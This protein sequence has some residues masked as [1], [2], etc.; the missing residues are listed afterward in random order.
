MM[1]GVC[2]NHHI[3][4]VLRLLTLYLLNQPKPKEE[5]TAFVKG[6]IVLAIFFLMNILAGM[7]HAEVSSDIQDAYPYYAV[8]DSSV[9]G[10][11]NEMQLL[12]SGIASFQKRIDL[13]RKAKKRISIEYFIWEKDKAGL[14]LF[15]ELIKKAKEGVDVRIILDKSIT[16]IEMDEFFAEAVS[17]YGIDL[18]HYNRAVDPS[19]AQF[20]T[21]RKI[22]V[23]DGNEGI[24]GGRNIGDD[25]FDFDEVYNFLDRDVYV[26]GPIAKAMQDSFDAFWNDPIVK[27]SRILDTNPASNRLHR[28][29]R[30]RR[31]YQAH[32]DEVLERLRK[33][34]SEWIESHE[35][36]KSVVQEMEQVARPILNKYPVI[37]C[38]K[39]TF[40]SDKPGAN[41]F[42][43]FLV[44]KYKKNFRV[45]RKVL[46]DFMENKTED[47]LYIASPYFMLNE[48]WQKTLS[49]ILKQGKKI[50]VFTNSLG[51][52]DAFYVA[53]N[54]YR[55]IP[56]WVE[57]GMDA[58][59]HNSSYDAI[60]P[61]LNETV[62]K[63]R[64]GM[65]EKTQIY[66]DEAFY[67]GTYNVDNRSD[68]YNAEMGVFCEGS[69]ELTK[70]LLDDMKL[71]KESN[72]KILSKDN[73]ANKSGEVVDYYGN[74]TSKQIKTMKAF[75][76]PAMLFEPLM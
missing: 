6:L 29:S 24:T 50:Q 48:D 70:N 73:A 7:V 47:T 69:Q 20:R 59:I 35:E 57:A 16:I 54:F 27:K 22:L 51:S 40:V 25:Y 26:K 52:T 62:E 23:I 61:V 56:K 13:V 66:S 60:D 67:V 71:R 36:M 8:N 4:P 33:E 64:W 11:S 75:T 45:T 46:F 19:T 15:H 65:H 14:V 9:S 49:N 12:H 76:L 74:A 53:A 17:K 42:K 10:E 44:K 2:K 39:A 34:A 32:K 55:I 38:P 37:S 18:R 31:R 72:Y 63:A 5:E 21:H 58:F 30:D 43:R 1:T 3:T 41:V 28:N 68:F